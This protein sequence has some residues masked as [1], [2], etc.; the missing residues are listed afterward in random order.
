[1]KFPNS[2]RSFVKNTSFLT[3]LL[4]SNPFNLIK[5]EIGHSAN[6][7][8]DAAR[9]RKKPLPP[10]TV[11][12]VVGM[13]QDFINQVIQ[14]YYTLNPKY[15][16]GAQSISQ[17]DLKLAYQVTTAPVL[18]ILSGQAQPPN[19]ISIGI[20]NI[21]CTFTQISG[22]GDVLA[23]LSL[24]VLI[25]GT[26]VED[27]GR[28]KIKANDVQFT[29]VTKTVVKEMQGCD[30]NKLI[31]HILDAFLK[32]YIN[33]TVTSIPL[34]NPPEIITGFKTSII[35]IKF[36]A[37]YVIVELTVLD[38]LANDLIMNQSTS[39]SLYESMYD[40][41]PTITH[42]KIDLAEPAIEILS[43]VRT[44]QTT[45]AQIFKGIVDFSGI[46]TNP[47]SAKPSTIRPRILADSQD[48]T[49]APPAYSLYAKFSNN[50]FQRL[51]TLKFNMKLDKSDQHNGDGEYWK[52]AYGIQT[53]NSTTHIIK[54]GLNVKTDVSGYANGEAGKHFF[55]PIG[56]LRVGASADDRFS[57]NVDAHT[58]VQRDREI[59]LNPVI[60][61][62]GNVNFNFRISPAILQYLIGWM[63]NLLLKGLNAFILT[64]I[65]ILS[66]FIKIK[67]FEIPEILP[68]SGVP[69]EIDHLDIG[70]QADMLVFSL[71]LK[72]K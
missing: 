27:Q 55:W 24:S 19:S 46:N 59:W 52:Y 23:K 4:L 28:I 67:L 2:R 15:F 12:I 39:L 65:Q 17:L 30:L 38:H 36:Q 44:M 31:E 13:H 33:T 72:V 1:M 57:V 62:I 18:T 5:A 66:F 3:G 41:H 16:Q 34:P 35:N 6:E 14:K 21:D 26:I 54:D 68:V 61:T 69:I 29:I 48:A 70:Q 63:I 51:A 10:A 56:W 45:E 22:A 43:G 53:S 49:Q 32:N 7:A 20:K 11:D 58:M 71:N 64:F 37:P 42:P 8:K 50:A 40:S 47:G 25:K 60:N 9:N